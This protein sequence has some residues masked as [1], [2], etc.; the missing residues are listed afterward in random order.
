MDNDI[1]SFQLQQPFRQEEAI[2]VS[3]A[4]IE[5]ITRSSSRNGIVTISYDDRVNRRF[6]E[7]VALIVSPST[8]IQ[9]ISGRRVDLNDLRVGMRVNAIFS[10]RMTRSIPPQA[11]AFLIVVNDRRERN[12]VT[13]GSIID[14]NLRNRTL[15][16][17]ETRPGRVEFVDERFS[18]GP[19][20]NRT[21]F[22]ITN[23]TRIE[24]RRGRR[25]NLSNIR[26]NDRVRVEFRVVREPRRP[27]RNVALFIQVL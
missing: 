26:R 17:R 7:L 13:E 22:Q 16:I 8:A 4:R 5:H 15:D 18:G 3:D 6:N 9:S 21:T 10:S 12:E 20:R 24:D 1:I 23:S 2:R 19:G 14:V 25:I 27:D 11:A